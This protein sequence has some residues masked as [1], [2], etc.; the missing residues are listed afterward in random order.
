MRILVTGAN[1]F[2]GRNLVPQLIKSGHE[3][4][5]SYRNDDFR[6]FDTQI[7]PISDLGPDT[8]WS[9]AL[10]KVE[11]VIHLAARVHVM[12]DKAKNLISDNKRIN[13]EGTR[14]LAKDAAAAGVRHF[15]FMST[16]KV[17]GESSDLKAFCYDDLPAPKDPYATAKLEAEKALA[18]V[19]RSS[20]MSAT[21]I[22]SPLVYGP[23][24]KGNFISLIKICMRGWPLP[25]GGVK[26]RRSIIY[27]GNL[28]DLIQR[29]INKPP[30]STKIY[31]CRDPQD[32]S[33]P[34]LIRKTC[35]ALGVKPL[36]I[37][38][39]L[40]VLH[41]I[42]ILIGKKA[43]IS[44]LTESL[45]VDDSPTRVDLDWTPPFSM[46]KGLKETATWFDTQK[47]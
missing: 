18:Q 9:K 11:T 26:N 28:V 47:H 43:T 17:N 35:T 15:I 6:Q 13:T 39:P 45:Y 2:I 44:R 3:V 4:V 10:I 16:I 8:D 40:S 30:S 21:I 41:F 5:A 23:G 29:V 27:V 24:V 25:F 22:R 32:V 46:L 19:V 31:L 12:T 20:N 1:G 36:I 14:K 42:A 33:T 34:E 7:Y 38:F 37:F